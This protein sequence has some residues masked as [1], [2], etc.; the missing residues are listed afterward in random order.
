VSQPEKQPAPGREPGGFIWLV[1]L[2]DLILPWVGVPLALIGLV[3][4]V[5]GYANGGWLLSIG[6]AML[7]ADAA[8]TFFWMRP[9]IGGT[10]QPLLNQRGSQYIGR[11]VRVTEDLIGGDGKVRIADTMWAARGPNCAAGTWV[12]VVAVD[13]ARLVVE[14]IDERHTE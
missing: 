12:K 2:I 10:D 9:A 14:P 4:S 1:G 6:V 5:R 3:L 11:T 8:L 13:G 7:V